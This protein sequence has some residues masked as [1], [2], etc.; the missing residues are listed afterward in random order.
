MTISDRPLE[1]RYE[2][3][4]INKSPFSSQIE[5]EYTYNNQIDIFSGQLFNPNVTITCEHSIPRWKITPTVDDSF[6]VQELFQ[7]RERKSISVNGIVPTGVSVHSALLTVSGWMEQYSI[8]NGTL[9]SDSC[10]TGNNRVSLSKTYNNMILSNLI[11]AYIDGGTGSVLLYYDFDDTGIINGSGALLNTAP[12]STVGAYTGVVE[13]GTIENFRLNEKS[14]GDFSSSH[15]KFGPF[16]EDLVS[17]GDYN[18]ELTFLFSCEK[19]HEDAGVLF[20]SLVRDEYDDGSAFGRGFNI[21][22]NSRNQIFFQGINEENGEFVLTA[23][24]IELANK[25]LCSVSVSPYNVTV[26]RYQ[27]SD[28]AYEEQ[29]LFTNGQIQNTRQDEP[30]YLGAAQTF[31]REGLHSLSGYIDQFMVISGFYTAPDLK[32]IMSGFV[33]TG[34]SNSGVSFLDTVITGHEIT[35]ILRSGVTGYEPVLTGYKQSITDSEFVEFTL[36]EEPIPLSRNDG[37]RFFTGYSLPS[38]LGDYREETS[39]LIENND[40]ATTGDQAFDTRGLIDSGDFVTRYTISTV[41]VVQ[42]T[43]TIPL[44]ELQP[45]TGALLDQP[46][47][48]EKAYLTGQVSRTG[49]IVEALEFKDDVIQ[50][51]KPDYLYYMEKRI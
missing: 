21:G 16:A 36:V 2:T 7:T 48:Y 50:Q 1:T 43:G 51:Y 20:G 9:L 3:Y 23:N 19:V 13:N 24:D 35:L 5:Y 45:R 22:L 12:S 37:D 34:V 44:Y 18:T 8:Q 46:T 31:Y 41:K 29:S 6:C 28:D 49:T 47:G 33:A 32:S 10:V 42:L 27:L 14:G 25:N 38:S 15:V 30:Y 17:S 11:N 40:Y 4:N 26:A 39:F